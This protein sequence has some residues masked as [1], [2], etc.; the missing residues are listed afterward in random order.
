MKSI[1]AGAVAA[2]TSQDSSALYINGVNGNSFTLTANYDLYTGYFTADTT[3]LH[4][5]RLNAGSKSIYIDNVTLESTG[6]TLAAGVAAELSGDGNAVG[7]VNDQSISADHFTQTTPANRPLLDTTGI[8]GY[9]ALEF[10]G[11]NDALSRAEDVI[12]V[13]NVT[14]LFVIKPRGVGGGG[15]G[16][17]IDNHAAFL[18][19]YN[20][21]GKQMQISSNGG[22]SVASSA[23]NSILF[24]NSHIVA[25]TRTS[26]GIA[27][28]YVDAALSGN[29]NQNTG[30]P[31]A[32]TATY[33]GNRAAGDRAFNGFIGDILIFQRILTLPEIQ[34]VSRYLGLKYGVEI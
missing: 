22:L 12:G 33:S 11:S 24:N 29:A 18:V 28:V 21:T 34:M 2:I 26:A 13:G 15:I 5:K 16:R 7:R 9:Y 31:A 1:T 3:T 32:G 14:V 25:V 19:M 6:P 30:S 23:A 4:V 20:D 10:D 17:V 27:N 8:G